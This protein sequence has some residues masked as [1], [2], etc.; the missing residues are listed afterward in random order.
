MRI[1]VEIT[2]LSSSLLQLLAAAKV[3]TFEHGCSE[4][5]KGLEAWWKSSP[6]WLKP[7]GPSSR[8]GCRGQFGIHLDALSLI[9][10]RARCIVYASSY[11]E[12]IMAAVSGSEFVDGKE[13]FTFK[14]AVGT[15]S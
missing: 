7:T 11:P 15:K 14:T 4:K 10:E 13:V 6:P 5:E 1:L 8:R 9:R 2:C 3:A 12:I